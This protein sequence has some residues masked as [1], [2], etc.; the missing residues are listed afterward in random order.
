MEVFIV[1]SWKPLALRGLA[2]VLFGILAF[3][4]PAITLVALV[5]VFGG[6]ALLDGLLA[7]AAA[8]RQN[9]REHAWTL[10]AEGLLG[11]GVGL[12]ALL[13]TGMTA[14]VLVN[15]IAFWAMFTGLLELILAV[16]LRR[17]IPGELLLGF[18]GAVS[19]LLGVVILTRPIASA[20]V[21]VVLLGSY[22]FCFGAAMLVLAFRLRRHKPRFAAP[23]L[24]FRS[25]HGASRI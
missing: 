1:R 9:A 10:A 7:L 22:A 6:Y 3:M 11:V 17:V 16:R 2:G 21:I 20:F 15:L 25:S 18:S 13:C 5:L 14:F 19:V 23:D 24:T 12:A 4:W 8:Q